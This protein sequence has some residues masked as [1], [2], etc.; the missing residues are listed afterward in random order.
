LE[1]DKLLRL[2]GLAQRAGKIKSGN[3]AADESV[4]KGACCLL[5][6]SSDTS[7]ASKKKARNMCAYYDTPYREYSDKEALGHAIGKEMRSVVAIED[8]GFAGKIL[9]ILESTESKG[10]SA[11]DGKDQ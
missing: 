8:A 9:A 5:L 2:L 6:V 3:F 1:Q 10:G 4:K 7:E 11:I